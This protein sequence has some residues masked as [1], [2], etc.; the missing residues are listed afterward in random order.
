MLLSIRHRTEYRYE[1]AL[2]Y[3]VM[4]L[5]VTPRSLG[6]QRVIDWR[7][8]LEGVER[9]VAF[10]DHLGNEVW[11][12]SMAQ[13]CDRVAVT[14]EGVVETRETAGVFGPHRALAPLWLFTRPTALT[15]PGEGVARLVADLGGP[16]AGG[17]AVA[18]V[19]AGQVG[20]GLA[21]R[22]MAAVADAVAYDVDDTHPATTAEEALARGAGVCQDHAH[23]MAA[24]A[25]R[26]GIPAR[27]VSGYLRLDDREDQTATHAW[28]EL[29]L[30]GLGWVGF[31][32]SNRISPDDRYVRLAVGRDYDEAAPMGGVR[33]GAHAE[34]LHV[35]L[36][37]GEQ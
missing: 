6:P 32:P 34:D 23:V 17:P 28:V 16:D 11:L 26:F 24:V 18:P 15:M 7:I 20:L 2:N 31:D 29:H 25:R 22:M 8:G 10:R 33:Y 14:A 37:V 19:V 9:Q 1:A 36:H 27:Y 35:H 4:R 5:R 3:G 21:H 13:G 12:V 30:E